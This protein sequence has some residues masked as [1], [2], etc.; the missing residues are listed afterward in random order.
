MGGDK[1]PP[2]YFELG[3]PRQIP[4]LTAIMIRSFCDGSTSIGTGSSAAM[5]PV[6]VRTSASALRC[7]ST[8]AL[9]RLSCSCSARLLGLASVVLGLGCTSGS[10]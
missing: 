2:S 8:R 7:R 3:V 10:S 4:A 9:G 1:E 6:G 5:V